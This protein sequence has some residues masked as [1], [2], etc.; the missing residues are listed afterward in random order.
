M[1]DVNDYWESRQ[2]ILYYQVVRILTQAISQGAESLIDV[3]SAGCPYLEWY[4]HVP[5][6]TSIDLRR[7]YEAAGVQSLVGNFL[8]WTPDRKY[9][10]ATC[11]QV[12]EHVAKAREFAQKLLA[13]AAVVV[14]SVPYK[15]PHGHTKSHVQD[16]VDERKMLGWFDREPNFSYIVNELKAPVQRLVCV[17][18]SFATPWDSLNKRA[19]L[20]KRAAASRG[21]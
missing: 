5:Y 12:L 1:A 6:R 20:L 16:P 14:I 10:V 2:E 17:Y 11:L 18:D 19:S 21:P 9:D 8:D 3:G 7:P 4:G 15:W 13:T